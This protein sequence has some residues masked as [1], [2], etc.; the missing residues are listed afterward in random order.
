V[1]RFL[2]IV[3]TL[4]NNVL[5]E[6]KK[7]GQHKEEIESMKSSLVNSDAPEDVKEASQKSG[8][9]INE[10]ESLKEQLTKAKKDNMCIRIAY[11]RW[12]QTYE[13]LDVLKGK[14]LPNEASLD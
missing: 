10:L 3:T 8:A 12:R 7:E 9:L 11:E 2:N 6:L 4:T 13:S 5:D 14:S 1:S